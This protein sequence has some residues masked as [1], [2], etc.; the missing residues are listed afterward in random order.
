[1]SLSH[2]QIHGR[3]LQYFHTSNT[4]RGSLVTKPGNL[5]QVLVLTFQW[6]F[7]PRAG[8]RFFNADFHRWGL[9]SVISRLWAIFRDVYFING[10]VFC[11]W[12]ISCALTCQWVYSKGSSFDFDWR[13]GK[14]HG[15]L[16]AFDSKKRK[17]IFLLLNEMVCLAYMDDAKVL[18][19]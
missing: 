9:I 15:F 18:I 4:V 1:M 7:H 13:L 2:K 10:M 8:N 11:V 14:N 17:K 6:V 5:W 19:G 16:I 12:L 3:C